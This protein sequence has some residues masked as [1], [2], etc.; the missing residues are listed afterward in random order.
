[1]TTTTAST[2]IAGRRPATGTMFLA[3]DTGIRIDL[4][5]DFAG[6]V[7]AMLAELCADN[8]I[9]AFVRDEWYELDDEDL[10]DAADTLQS[11]PTA[12]NLELPARVLARFPV[13]LTTDILLG[14]V[15]TVAESS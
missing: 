10:A 15:A 13:D 14:V 4:P 6:N 2:I 7:A 11:D 5:A 12:S 1:V 8:D 9:R 3:T